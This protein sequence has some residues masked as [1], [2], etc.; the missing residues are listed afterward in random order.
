LIGQG[1]L[2]ELAKIGDLSLADID[3]GHWPMLTAPAEL[4]RLIDQAAA[5][6]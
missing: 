5:Q 2:P 1:E 3:S 6:S 4:A